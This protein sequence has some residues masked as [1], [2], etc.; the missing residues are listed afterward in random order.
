LKIQKKNKHAFLI[1]QV[2]EQRSGES[3]VGSEPTVR[4]EK[5]SQHL[6]QKCQLQKKEQ[7]D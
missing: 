7:N 1:K 5:L 4:Q 6:G 3:I 2:L